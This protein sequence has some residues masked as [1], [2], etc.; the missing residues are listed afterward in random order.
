LSAPSPALAAAAW[1][2]SACARTLSEGAGCRR[3]A[4]HA[5]RAFLAIDDDGSETLDEQELGRLFRKM[6]LQ[7][8][9]LQ[10]RQDISAGSGQRIIRVRTVPPGLA[11]HSS[12]ARRGVGRIGY[13]SSAGLLRGCCRCGRRCTRWTL[14]GRAR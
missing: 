9:G 8:N 3:A 12:C 1:R 7:M 6:G 5:R 10:V 13:R 11:Q 14:T 2:V 4:S